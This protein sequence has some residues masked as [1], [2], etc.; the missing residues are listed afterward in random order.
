MENI[1]IAPITK[2]DELEFIGNGQAKFNLNN[3]DEY[4]YGVIY[5]DCFI[6]LQKN[7]IYPLIYEA[8]GSISDE[9]FDLLENEQEYVFSS[10]IMEIDLKNVLNEERFKLA[11]LAAD[12][13]DFYK[14]ARA[15]LYNEEVKPKENKVI[16]FTTHKK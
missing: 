11:R 6:T 2:I 13:I 9:C 14:E 8:N 3:T 5:D 12:A 7:T 1:V 4:Y 15:K 16:P 10:N